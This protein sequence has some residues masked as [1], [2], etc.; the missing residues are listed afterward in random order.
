MIIYDRL[1]ETMKE[2]NV[3][4]YKLI[5]EYNLSRGQLTRLK[6]NASVT[7]NTI[8][9]LCKILNCR[10]EDIIEFVEDD[11]PMGW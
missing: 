1:W 10:V 7:T 5:K 4:T 2:K 9:A 8:N 11:E 6:K 3:T